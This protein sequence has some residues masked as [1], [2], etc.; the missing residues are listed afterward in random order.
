[1]TATGSSPTADTA[2]EHGRPRQEGGEVGA[3]EGVDPVDVDQAAPT[4]VAAP[5]VEGALEIGV[6]VELDVG[7]GADR[8]RRSGHSWTSSMS[9]PKLPFGWT[10]AT[11]V[12]RLPGRGA[13]SMAVA[14]AATMASSAAAQ[15]S[16][17]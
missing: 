6:V 13:S 1:M 8:A 14:P 9:V 10:K 15:S 2:E 16:T 17:R 5:V 4:S 11:V 7:D 12:P 3:V